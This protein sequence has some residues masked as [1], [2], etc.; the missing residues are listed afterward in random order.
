M[1]TLLTV[2]L[3]W[4]M[5]SPSPTWAQD[6]LSFEIT[7]PSSPGFSGPDFTQ[8]ELGVVNVTLPNI[9]IDIDG[10]VIVRPTSPAIYGIIEDPIAFKGAPPGNTFVAPNGED[11]GLEVTYDESGPPFGDLFINGISFVFGAI[12]AGQFPMPFIDTQ[13]T[14]SL[15]DGAYIDTIDITTS[16]PV[17]AGY[18]YT[19]GPIYNATITASDG[20]VAIGTFGYGHFVIP[21]P[22][23]IGLI[24]A[25]TPMV[26]ARRHRRG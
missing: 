13:L 5:A 8:I 3:L 17:W 14:V 6:W 10:R 22:S 11:N 18:I 26:L 15:N 1:R 19:A 2:A 16:E 4:L 24:L 20:R 12:N 9:F 7:P 21:E 25:A 23:T